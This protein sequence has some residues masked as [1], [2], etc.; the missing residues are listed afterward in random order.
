MAIT[1]KSRNN[2]S[3][4]QDVIEA[5]G[6]RAMWEGANVWTLYKYS[7]GAF[8]LEG[9]VRGKKTATLESLISELSYGE[10]W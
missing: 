4:F 5:K 7:K 3:P 2:M 6:Y 9:K 1:L 8:I 10:D